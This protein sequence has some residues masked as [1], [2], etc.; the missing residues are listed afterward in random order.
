MLCL[1][2]LFHAKEEIKVK[3]LLLVILIRAIM[4]LCV[5]KQS[6]SFRSFVQI[7]MH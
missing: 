6:S 2:S 3:V 1:T 4:L 5:N 7:T